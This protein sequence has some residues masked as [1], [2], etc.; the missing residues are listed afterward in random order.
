MG[1]IILVFLCPAVLVV[2]GWAGD[3]PVQRYRDEYLL[4]RP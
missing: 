2:A 4:E 1:R 3:N